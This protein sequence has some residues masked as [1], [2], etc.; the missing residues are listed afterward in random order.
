MK[1][2]RA[3][4]EDHL[5]YNR[6][7]VLSQCLYMVGAYSAD[8]PRLLWDTLSRSAGGADFREMHDSSMSVSFGRECLKGGYVLH[9]LQTR[10]RQ[11]H[12]DYIGFKDDFEPGD[13][14][15]T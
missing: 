11:Y 5:A 7:I 8:T 4:L 10:G 9:S 12:F 15:W 3:S 1:E 14:S 13:L 6:L 2:E